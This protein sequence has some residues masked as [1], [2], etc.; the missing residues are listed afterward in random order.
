MLVQLLL[1]SIPTMVMPSSG[2]TIRVYECVC[3]CVGGYICVC[4]RACVCV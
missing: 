2:I 3:V 4:T 1:K